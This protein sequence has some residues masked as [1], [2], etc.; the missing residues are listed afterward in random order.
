[1]DNQLHA[2]LEDSIHEDVLLGIGWLQTHIEQR[3]ANTN[4]KPDPDGA[5]AALY[6]DGGSCFE[7]RSPLRR[8]QHHVQVISVR[9]ATP[10][11]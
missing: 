1:M 8:P 4:I 2:W 10:A 3:V 6:I 7:I 11:R 9:T 5:W